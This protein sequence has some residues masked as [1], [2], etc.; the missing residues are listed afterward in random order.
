MQPMPL[1]QHLLQSDVVLCIS[2][3]QGLDNVNLDVYNT[4]TEE[5]EQLQ[6]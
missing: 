1:S 4:K 2:E 5:A 6:R 3:W